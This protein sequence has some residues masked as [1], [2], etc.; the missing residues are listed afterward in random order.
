MGYK[1]FKNDSGYF[2]IEFILVLTVF[3]LIV[4]I[5]TNLTYSES[6]KITSTLEEDSLEKISKEAIDYIINSPDFAIV[7][8]DN[9][10]IKNTV[11]Y[12]KISK[13]KDNYDLIITNNL[14]NNKIKSSLSIYPINSN[15]PILFFGENNEGSDVFQI[16]RLIKCDYFSNFTLIDFSKTTSICNQNH[17]SSYKCAYFKVNNSYLKNTDF[18]LLFNDGSIENLYYSLDDTHHHSANFNKVLSDKIYLND[19]ISNNLKNNESGIIFI[20]F[21]DENPKGLLVA[22]PKNFKSEFLSYNYFTTNNCKIV[23]RTWY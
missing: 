16:T 22:I 18:Y 7:N 12:S 1:M 14:F 6:E 20:H 23:L 15:L 8:S 17:N 21:K 5:L 3:I 11:S 9:K 2:S 19:V 10:T 13:L 4:G